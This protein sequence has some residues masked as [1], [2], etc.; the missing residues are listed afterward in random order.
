ML[1][2]FICSTTLA[3]VGDSIVYDNILY[4]I[5]KHDD[6]AKVY[7]VEIAQ[8]PMQEYVSTPAIVPYMGNEYKVTSYKPSMLPYCEECF[9]TNIPDTTLH[10]TKI[11]LSKEYLENKERKRKS[12][13]ENK[14]PLIEIEKDD[15]RDRQ[16]LTDRIISEINKLAKKHFN[17]INRVNTSRR[18]P[19]TII[20]HLNAQSSLI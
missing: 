7:E 9:D 16:G 19:Y 6:L 18:C 3:N 11:D 12:Y 14:I 5:T 8:L 20:N 4:T 13:K 17:I 10:V 2:L 1:S 15:Y